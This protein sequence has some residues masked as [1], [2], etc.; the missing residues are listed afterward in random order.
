MNEDVLQWSLRVQSVASEEREFE[1]VANAMKQFV[2]SVVSRIAGF[3]AQVL[4]VVEEMRATVAAGGT[5]EGR[6]IELILELPGEGEFRQALR[7]LE[8]RFVV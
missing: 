5:A 2:G 3:G 8:K 4:D 1:D 7:A 6:K